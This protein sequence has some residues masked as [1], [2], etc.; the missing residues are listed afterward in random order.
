MTTATPVFR[1]EI[2]NDPRSDGTYDIELCARCVAERR[3]NHR[4]R[5]AKY[6]RRF[7]CERGDGI[8]DDCAALNYDP[9]EYDSE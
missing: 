1:Y 7:E 4:A 6:F 3:A 5:G 2:R 9:S 8:C